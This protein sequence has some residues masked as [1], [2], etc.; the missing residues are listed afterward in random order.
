MGG[1]MGVVR[2]GP[3]RELML[4]IRDR[5]S[6]TEF[7]E[8]GTADGNTAGWASRHFQHVT[9]IELNDERYRAATN[10]YGTRDNIEFIKGKSQE[11]LPEIVTTLTA[12]AICW[13]DAH[14]AGGG[15]AGEGYEC[16]LLDELEALGRSKQSHHLFIDDARL[17]CSPPPEPYSTDDWPTISEVIL[18]IVDAFGEDYYV[19]ITEDV[20]IAVPPAA[21]EAVVDY[22][23]DGVTVLSSQGQIRHGIRI[24]YKGLIDQVATEQRVAVMKKSRLYPYARK[25]YHILD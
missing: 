20:I 3:P 10:Q 9:T 4:E 5:C 13:L 7:I 25:I 21:K 8:T 23:R 18:A 12:P 14:Y 6:I 24:A 11:E 19:A 1:C 22:A 2:R 15:T 16:P 17:F